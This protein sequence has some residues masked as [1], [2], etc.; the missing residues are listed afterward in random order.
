MK[1][2]KS[3]QVMMDVLLYTL[4][5]F[6]LLMVAYG[7][8]DPIVYE[9]TNHLENQFSLSVSCL[10]SHSHIYY[11]AWIKQK[12]MTVFSDKTDFVDKA[13]NLCDQ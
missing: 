5:L 4:F 2:L 13:L 8:R 1:E 3:S 7:H 12:V 11:F 10:L 9:M 6:L